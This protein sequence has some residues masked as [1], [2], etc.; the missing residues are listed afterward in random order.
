MPSDGESNW[1]EKRVASEFPA[2][3]F[4]IVALSVTT[5]LFAQQGLRSTLQDAA[6][7]EYPRPGVCMDWSALARHYSDSDGFIGTLLGDDCGL[8]LEP[9][10][11]GEV[12]T[13]TR[14]GI[15]TREAT[16]YEALLDLALTLDFEKLHWPL[17]GRFFVLAQ[18]S[19]GRGLTSDFI[20][21]FQT[22]SN[23]DS[24]H[25]IMQVSEYWWEIGLPDQSV[26]VRLGKQDLNTEFLVMDLA[27]DFIH[28]SFGLSPTAGL[29]SYPDPSMAA[30][31]LA[32]L[33]K[34][35]KLKIGLW[36]A[37]ARGGSWGF[38]GNETTITLGE[39]E[40]KYALREGSLPG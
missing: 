31:V 26:T 1:G 9:V 33:T 4:A 37:L 8:F 18:N 7:A 5:S 13:N 24:F 38:S 34:S 3:A 32:Q 17:P 6:P 10:Y 27:G 40:Y 11:Y 36:D 15:S 14:G 23:I 35:L 12:F 16:Q 25:N 28:S 20:G 30:V 2:I 19:H 39:L 22:L 29:P 21:D